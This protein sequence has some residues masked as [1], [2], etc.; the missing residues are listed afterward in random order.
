MSVTN[1]IDD[2]R[3]TIVQGVNGICLCRESWMMEKKDSETLPYGN[4]TGTCAKK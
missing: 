3:V 1:L 2:E 4:A